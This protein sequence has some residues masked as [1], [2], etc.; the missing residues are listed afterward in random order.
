MALAAEKLWLVGAAIAATAVPS[1]GRTEITALTFEYTANNE[2]A[3][4][5]SLDSARA[6]G[7]YTQNGPP[8]LQVVITSSVSPSAFGPLARGDAFTI[9]APQDGTYPHTSYLYL[10]D[11]SN[12][13]GG[14]PDI[15]IKIDTSCSHGPLQVS[16]SFGS[17]R[18]TG[19]ATTASENALSCVPSTA[20]LK[21][22]FD[23]K[24]GKKRKGG[25]K[26]AVISARQAT[27]GITRLTLQYIKTD[28]TTASVHRLPTERFSITNELPLPA[29][30]EIVTDIDGKE[31]EV[32][33][34]GDLFELA[35]DGGVLPEHT[36]MYIKRLDGRVASTIS[37]HTSCAFGGITVGDVMGSVKVVAV[38]T[39]L[40]D[41]D[42][43]CA[44]WAPPRNKQAKRG[45]KTGKHHREQADAHD[46]I[47]SVT[48]RYLK[49]HERAMENGLDPTKWSYDKG[50]CLPS[51]AVVKTSLDDQEHHVAGSGTFVLPATEETA[52]VFPVYTSLY[53]S[54]GD[55]SL[56]SACSVVTLHTSCSAGGIAVGDVF[57]PLEVVAM[58]TTFNGFAAECGREAEE[59][60][61]GNSDRNSAD[62]VDPAA[63]LPS[64]GNIS[65]APATFDPTLPGVRTIKLR[66][67][68][69]D[70][71]TVCSNRQGQLGGDWGFLNVSFG[72][73]SEKQ[74]G[75]V[76][77]LSS[78]THYVVEADDAGEFEITAEGSQANQ[79]FF[80]IFNVNKKVGECFF[81]TACGTSLH[82]GDQ[83]GPLQ[84]TAVSWK[85]NACGRGD[86]A[87]D[88]SSP[89]CVE[90]AAASTS[91]APVPTTAKALST[92]R[93]VPAVSTTNSPS[94]AS[95]TKSPPVVTT[96]KVISAGTTTRSPT[97]TNELLAQPT[98]YTYTQ[99]NVEEPEN[100]AYCRVDLHKQEAQD[101]GCITSKQDTVYLNASV[102][103]TDQVCTTHNTSAT[104]SDTTLYM[105]IQPADCRH[106][107]DT[108]PAKWRVCSWQPHPDVCSDMSCCN[109]VDRA[110]PATTDPSIKDL[111][112]Q[113]YE[114]GDCKHIIGFDGHSVQIYTLELVRCQGEIPVDPGCQSNMNSR[115]AANV[116]DAEP[117]SAGRTGSYA[118]GFL[119]L[120]M[121][122]L[123]MA[124]YLRRVR[125]SSGSQHTPNYSEYQ[126]PQHM[127]EAC[128]RSPLWQ[129]ELTCAALYD[130]PKGEEADPFPDDP[131]LHAEDLNALLETQVAPQRPSSSYESG[132][133]GHR[134]D[135]V[136]QG[137]GTEM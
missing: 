123:A 55:Q 115:F 31:A 108:S 65:S 25:K 13:K 125:L 130:E 47:T 40:N 29:T 68:G 60:Q 82:A 4:G 105:T 99:S 127:V 59:D 129:A 119:G 46:K 39:T 36:N 51:H 33:K 87:A 53:L 61:A 58:S 10:S 9:P 91:S 23:S 1:A 28:A 111:S 94:V 24:K 7:S 16:D 62:A 11:A 116:A 84:I 80:E 48:L 57:G 41:K 133:S 92:T 132:D 69:L 118:V 77:L 76:R 21:M 90:S 86:T 17:L 37:I 107:G 100:L 136:R 3:E 96:T 75:S 44:S 63:R 27:V 124:A 104:G 64:G 74:A 49:S 122:L 26:G 85:D 73:A 79:A 22:P 70:H 30:V 54:D 112:C 126:E 5:N 103:F 83:F 113:V 81:S 135:T 97:T 114:E 50:G 117:A 12:D 18:I 19:M 45:K 98:T 32:L 67:V 72:V 93:A 15:V 2:H 43:E 106:P 8:P 102:G 14:E 6:E 34:D 52:G 42:T 128:E 134:D 38:A 121:F 137:L 66:F 78:M 35:A 88:T 101:T 89:A 71:G 120:G 109:S 131:Y 110:L 20:E 56:F 95:R